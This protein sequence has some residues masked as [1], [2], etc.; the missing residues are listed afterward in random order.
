[1]NGLCR[2]SYADPVLG[3]T[4]SSRAPEFGCEQVCVP[5]SAMYAFH[6]APLAVT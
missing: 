5:M 6:V 4:A 1:M 3:R 2:V